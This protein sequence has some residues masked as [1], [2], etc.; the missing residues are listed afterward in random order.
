MNQPAI[1][2]DCG[3][4]LPHKAPVGLCPAG[5]LL[6][7]MDGGS[8]WS[9]GEDGDGDGE[10]VGETSP[11]IHEDAPDDSSGRIYGSTIDSP[12][13]PDEARGTRFP[14][15][16]GR[17]RL[18]REVS[19]ARRQAAMDINSAEVDPARFSEAVGNRL[20]SAMSLR[21]V[22][23]AEAPGRACSDACEAMVEALEGLNK[24]RTHS[25]R[26]RSRL[27]V[28]FGIVREA[29]R[30]QGSPLAV[31]PVHDACGEADQA[32]TA[33]RAAID[34]IAYPFPLALPEALRD[35]TRPTVGQFLGHDS[36]DRDPAGVYTRGMNLLSSPRKLEDRI[37]STLAEMTERVEN[38]LG[39]PSLPD[40]PTVDSGGE[41]TRPII[42]D[43]PAAEA[44][45][46]TFTATNTGSPGFPILVGWVE[47]SEPH[48]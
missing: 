15:S 21:Q 37:L 6:Q 43:G 3:Q 31:R 9:S 48:Q 23:D 45:P 7:G 24:A 36:S 39:L 44:P 47:R 16:F 22:T 30:E 18:E 42:G 33:L 28:L 40:P 2:P 38:S 25:D 19:A 35:E 26:L 13:P 17:Y 46:G 29:R 41:S 34:G 8:L 14:S 5:L 11:A 20:G 4:A 32:I 10:T 27:S 1:R 12:T